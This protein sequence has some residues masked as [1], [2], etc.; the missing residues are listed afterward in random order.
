MAVALLVLFSALM[1]YAALS[2]IL[3]MTIPNRISLFLIAAFLVGAVAAGMPL[4]GIGA[5]LAAGIL[6]L[7]ITF[8]LFSLGIFGGGDPKMAAA[9]A[10]WCG[11][12]GLMDFALVTALA[13]G[14][15][16]AA[17]LLAR[18]V[19]PQAWA[20]RREWTARL[21]A[22]TTGVPYGVALAVA[23]AMVVPQSALL[24]LAGA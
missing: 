13:G 4:A 5:H 9:T 1:A 21:M 22:P 6:M 11:F 15:L 19:V 17:I 3:T 2:D 14:V 8:A 16:T 7:G 23:G 18:K 24:R 12:A 20:A 10:L